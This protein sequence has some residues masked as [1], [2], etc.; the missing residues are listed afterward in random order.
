[1]LHL[2]THPLIAVRAVTHNTHL[3]QRFPAQRSKALTSFEQTTEQPGKLAATA[4]MD[5]FAANP[6]IYTMS[7]RTTIRYE[8]T[9]HLHNCTL[10]DASYSVQPTALEY[11]H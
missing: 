1:M 7:S 3:A 9:T 4:K 8:N 2:S 11:V 6:E 10:R 5:I